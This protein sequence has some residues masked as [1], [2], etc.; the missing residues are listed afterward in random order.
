MSDGRLAT[1]LWIGA[2]LRRCSADGMPATVVHSGE[3]MGGAVMLKVYQAGQGCRLMAQMR[4]LDG[5]LRWY[6]AHK[7]ELVA[8][9]EAEALIGRAIARD[10]DLW[11][12]EVESR[13]GRN[14][15]EE[16]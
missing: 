3:R 13:D 10:P 1:H 16:D 15:F 8:E 7:E 2:L 6:K 11:V 12:I 4:D 14:P 5:R 9:G